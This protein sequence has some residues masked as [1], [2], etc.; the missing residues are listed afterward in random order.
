MTSDA[1][2]GQAVEAD[3]S[4]AEEGVSDREGLSVEEGEPETPA[5][6]LEESPEATDLD[7]AAP[8]G[9]ESIE[10]DG[11]SAESSDPGSAHTSRSISISD[12][13]ERSVLLTGDIGGLYLLNGA[14]SGE[15]KAEEEKSLIDFTHALPGRD[16][17]L[18]RFAL[19]ELEEYLTRLREERIILVCC[20]CEDIALSAVYELLDRLN[21]AIEDRRML[22]FE[23]GSEESSEISVYSILTKRKDAAVETALLIDAL[24]DKSQMFIDSLFKSRISSSAIKED[25]KSN[26]IWLLCNVD[27]AYI[28]RK[29]QTEK[30]GLKFPLWKIPFLRPILELNHPSEAGILEAKILS[31]RSAGKW[32]RAEVEF[33]DQIDEAIKRG[34]LPGEINSLDEHEP[35]P[36]E[37]LFKDKDPVGNAVLYVA[38]HFPN[39]NHKMFD[40]LVTLLLKNMRPTF[41]AAGYRKPGE[42]VEYSRPDDL[43]PVQVWQEQADEKRREC[44]LEATSL[45]DSVRVISFSDHRLRGALNSYME[46]ERGFYLE[47]QLLILQQQ[48][49]LFHP[50]AKVA[51]SLTRLIVDKAVSQ[52]EDY[53]LGWLVETVVKLKQYS[54]PEA[55]AA[56][57]SKAP[58]FQCLERAQR[59][60]IGFAYRR[61]SLLIRE[62]LEYPEL[63]DVVSEFLERL[64]SPKS[65]D[66]CLQIIKR[67]RFAPNLDEFHWIRQL[68]ERGNTDIRIQASRYLYSY[69]KKME[70]NIYEILAVLKAWLPE[71]ERDPRTYSDSNRVALRLL[72]DYCSESTARFEAKHSRSWLGR[73]PLFAAN[74]LTSTEGNFELLVGWLFH[75]GMKAALPRRN[76]NYLVGKLILRWAYLLRGPQSDAGNE[77]AGCPGGGDLPPVNELSSS[78]SPELS[79]PETLNS[80]LGH[81]ASIATKQQR[82]E[83]MAA[84]KQHHHDLLNQAAEPSCSRPRREELASKRRLARQV[85]RYFTDLQRGRF[86]TTDGGPLELRGLQ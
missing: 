72:L 31:Q 66:S 42:A 57:S 53:S 4:A 67:L 2:E 35:I 32:S 8:E 51:E 25:L 21:I 17:R 41:S 28:E 83:L 15:G 26:G 62:M 22:N 46:R 69:V 55:A 19:A 60:G 85:I 40:E 3:D 24:G 56:G 77:V 80:L 29:P 65:Y 54:G 63:K 38:T 59:N 52:A 30:G 27:A 7:E 12:S 49:L 14:L 68:L 37:S 50:S 48:G 9:P 76:P 16:P 5:L 86:T 39:L 73:H 70:P 43:T 82:E 6:I 1:D 36:P 45:K 20:P 11:E 13:V 81:V 44:S 78:A 64:I 58:L 10:L 23:T 47:R 61:V 75:P 33:Y 74:D 84:W 34:N 79:Q 71:K 18:P